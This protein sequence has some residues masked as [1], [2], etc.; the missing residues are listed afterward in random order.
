ME[1]FINYSKKDTDGYILNPAQPDEGKF[2]WDNEQYSGKIIYHLSDTD[3]L[4]ISKSR[5][6]YTYQYDIKT[7][8]GM[9]TTETLNIG[10][11]TKPAPDKTLNFRFSELKFSDYWTITGKNYSPNPAKTHDGDINLNWNINPKNTLTFGVS[12][13][14]DKCDGKTYSL[15]NPP[16]IDTSKLLE[17]SGGKTTTKSIYFQDEMKFDSKITMIVGGRYDKWEFTNGYNATDSISEKSEDSFSPKASFL[18]KADANTTWYVSAGKSFSSPTIFNLARRWDVLKTLLLPNPDLK[19]EKATSYE[20]G[21]THQMSPNTT[22]KVSLFQNNVT[23][24]IYQAF[25]RKLSATKNELQWKNA[26]EAEIKGV[27][28]ELNHKFSPET[29]GY[30]NFTHNNAKITANSDATLID[31]QVP[32]VPQD[33]FNIGLTH[34]HKKLIANLEARYL[35]HTHE[36]DKNDEPDHGYGAYESNFIVDTK[37]GYHFT[38]DTSLS[39]AVNN[40][41]DRQ[42]YRE[43]LAQG[44]TV[45]VEL[46]Q[47]F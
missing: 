7:D 14:V 34:Q 25:I 3:K 2:G 8:R 16:I 37:F 23:D 41:F 39:L 27:E 43:T 40:L 42:Y 38:P 33:A 6:E 46:T 4:T 10:Y 20:F 36:S 31:K 11:Q 24:M 21:I 32:T 45:F 9:R 26:G 44:R 12:A 28:L 19:P 47:K 1:Y 22:A 5:S 18:Y 35:S 15:T 30:I 13:K 29:S 17:R